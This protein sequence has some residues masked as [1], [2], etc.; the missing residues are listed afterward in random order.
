MYVKHTKL[1]LCLLVFALLFAT[2]AYALPSGFVLPTPPSTFVWI[3][4]PNVKACIPELR[5]LGGKDTFKVQTHLDW[6][7][8]SVVQVEKEN[9]P[10]SVVTRTTEFLSETEGVD[11]IKVNG[12]LHQIYH[13]YKDDL[14]TT[15]NSTQPVLFSMT[16]YML[17]KQ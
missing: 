2:P 12:F 11:Y 9:N 6:H 14:Y 13:I 16:T 15:L 8:E 17:V 3:V 1:M 5:W 7:Y 10:N 4:Y